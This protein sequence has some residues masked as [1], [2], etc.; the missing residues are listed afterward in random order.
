LRQLGW[1]R[2]GQRPQSGDL[3]NVAVGGV[4]DAAV[5]VLGEPFPIELSIPAFLAA[6]LEADGP[7]RAAC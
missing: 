1:H 5:S 3:L 7:D 2:S 6:A 4:P